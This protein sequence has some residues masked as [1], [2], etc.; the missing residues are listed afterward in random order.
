MHHIN[1]DHGANLWN[2]FPC[3]QIDSKPNINSAGILKTLKWLQDY[4]A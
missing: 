4:K 2:I 1:N 3:P